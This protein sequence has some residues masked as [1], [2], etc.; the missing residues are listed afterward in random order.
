MLRASFLQ[1]AKPCVSKLF[2]PPLSK[3]RL[4]SKSTSSEI[5]N[6]NANYLISKFHQVSLSRRTF[7]KRAPPADAKPPA[8]PQK[9][10][11]NTD[12]LTKIPSLDKEIP[13]IAKSPLFTK[14]MQDPPVKITELPNGIRVVT[15]GIPTHTSAVSIIV[16]A[17]TKYED[18]SNEGA[19]RFL[20]RMAFKATKSRSSRELV[21]IIE[22]LGA[23]MMTSSSREMLI[24]SGECIQEHIPKL[25]ETMAETM[26]EP[27]FLSEEIDEQKKVLARELEELDDNLDGYLV[28]QLH[29]VAFSGQP[30]GRSMLVPWES[31]DNMTTEKLLDFQKKFYTPSRMVV[32]VTGGEHESIVKLV[33][34]NFKMAPSAITIPPKVSTYVGG[35]RRIPEKPKTKPQSVLI[36]SDRPVSHIYLAFPAPSIREPEFFTVSTLVSLL[37]GGESFSSGGPGKGMHSRLYTNVLGGNEFVEACSANVFTYNDCGLFV[38]QGK[39]THGTYLDFLNL[40]FSDLVDL[41]QNMTQEEVQRAKNQLKS[42]I[43]MALESRSVKASDTGAQILFYGRKFPHD[44]I[45]KTIDRLTVRDMQICL[46]KLLTAKPTMVAYG[47]QTDEI[48]TVETLQEVLGQNLQIEL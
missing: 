28:E 18:E 41:S 30:L 47:Q 44:E 12:Y 48:P 7:G 39:V 17:G 11:I 38:L 21:T 2:V 20:E 1:K 16:D 13:G 27:L 26:T 3:G 35:E 43:F 9:L 14:E 34:K 22:D 15:E 45:V 24:Y 10:K 25:I 36:P 5:L 46:N 6:S 32:S 8:P 40:L 29:E 42:N 31:L 33:Q 4:V 19:S 37:G 23:N